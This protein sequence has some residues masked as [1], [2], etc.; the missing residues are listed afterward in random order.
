M[1]EV[2]EMVLDGIL[3]EVCGVY[4]D[5]DKD[6]GHPRKCEDCEGEGE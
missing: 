1:G 5:D 3:C 2:S 4:I 6:P